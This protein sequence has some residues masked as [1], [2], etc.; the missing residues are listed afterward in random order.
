MIDIDFFRKDIIIA[1][2]TLPDGELLIIIWI[3]LLLLAKKHN[4]G[5]LIC[6]L[7]NV[8]VTDELLAC[9]LNTRVS[10]VTYALNVFSDYGM[11]H[12]KNGTLEIL[13]LGEYIK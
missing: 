10:F 6:F 3:K 7:K 9:F 13:N 12:R 8:D 5:G 2:E 1:L 4:K 11:I